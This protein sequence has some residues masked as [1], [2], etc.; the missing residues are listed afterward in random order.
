MI[1]LLPKRETLWKISGG[2]GSLTVTRRSREC[3]K[4][5][6]LR[7]L[8]GVRET[9]EERKK[10]N[11]VNIPHA[12]E[13]NVREEDYGVETDGDFY[14]DDDDSKD[15]LLRA[16]VTLID[17]ERINSQTSQIIVTFVE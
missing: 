15:T 16:N 10:A 17:G 9:K 5:N 7:N 2:C 4:L 11:F 8:L 12:H 6:A 13:D 3:E 1:S 14:N